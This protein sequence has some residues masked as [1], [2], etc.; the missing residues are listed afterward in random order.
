MQTAKGLEYAHR[1]GIIHRDIKPANLLVDK[2]GNIKI[3][4]MGLARVAAAATPLDAAAAERLT[5]T[6]QVM[7]TLDYMAPEQAENV[8][9]ADHRS[10]IYSLGCTLF[11]LL[12]GSSL[13]SGETIVQILLAH[14]EAA[15]P[16]LRTQCPDVPDWLDPIFQKL[17]AKRP[18]DRYQSLSEFVQAV[19]GSLKEPAPSSA[20]GYSASVPASS[21]LAEPRGA[22]EPPPSATDEDTLDRAVRPEDTSKQEP[23]VD[24][25]LVE[26]P[27]T[28]DDDNRSSVV[29]P[30]STESGGGVK[31][32]KSHRANQILVCGVLGFLLSWCLLG[33]VFGI[34]AWVLGHSDLADM[35]AGKMD[36]QGRDTTKVGMILG[37]A[38]T[39]IAG[40][41]AG[42]GYW[43]LW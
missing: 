2:E 11:R 10:D 6:G 14:R 42:L 36:A 21:L 12:T 20:T 23:P 33:A 22:S 28:I 24:A 1:R 34:V 5:T 40:L 13:Y 25:E 9:T 26:Q 18:E 39:V 43:S 3:L 17:V 31:I 41:S 19:E 8:R 4:D 7:G 30:A 16:S 27:A 32:V 29:S 35:R 15:I 38:A 37:I